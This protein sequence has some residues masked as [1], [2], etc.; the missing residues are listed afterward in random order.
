MNNFEILEKFSLS[1][2]I[3]Y[4]HKKP[5]PISRIGL[6]ETINLTTFCRLLLITIF[7]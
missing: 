3:F 4:N 2:K 6:E 5:G 7:S 1:I